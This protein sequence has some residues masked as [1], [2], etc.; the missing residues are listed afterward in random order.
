LSPSGFRV[1]EFK[2]HSGEF[3]TGMEVTLPD[4]LYIRIHAAI[5]GVLHMSG[6]GKFLDELF[7]K[8]NEGGSSEVLS[9]DDFGRHLEIADAGVG[10][11]SAHVQ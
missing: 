11:H 6:A 8:F 1:L 7:E 10:L 3:E 9:W 5:A 4:P 2:D